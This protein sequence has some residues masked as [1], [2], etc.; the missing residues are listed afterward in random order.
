MRRETESKTAMQEWK[1][2]KAAEKDLPEILEI[3][4]YARKF[5]K[6]NGN[7]HQWSD[8]F[9][10]EALLRE[11]IGHGNLYVVQK[12]GT[13]HVVFAFIVGEDV[14]YSVIE[15]GTWLSGEP[16]G[17]IHRVASDGAVHG[18]FDLIVSF[19]SQKMK[20]IR[21]D[22]HKDNKVMQHLILKNGFEK[23]GI[24]HVADGTPRIAY[25]KR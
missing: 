2:E 9:P 18:V 20:H 24:I 23:C 5:M 22:T 14:N 6:E 16:Y 13:I 21:I 1:I 19:C 17:T 12:D 11:D 3:Y 10:P 4:A 8:Q 7:A 15:Q 25:E